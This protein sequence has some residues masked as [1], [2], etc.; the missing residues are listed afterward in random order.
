MRDCASVV[1][2]GGCAKKW[3]RMEQERWYGGRKD[4][5]WKEF[6]MYRKG[7]RKAEKVRINEGNNYMA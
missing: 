7:R 1:I 5:G 4:E 2:E 3:K 6:K